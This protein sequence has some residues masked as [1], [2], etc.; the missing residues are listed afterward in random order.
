MNKFVILCGMILCLS[1]CAVQAEQNVDRFVPSQGLKMNESSVGM[2]I[3]NFFRNNNTQNNSYNQK[4]NNY[5]NN[6]ENNYNYNKNNQNKPKTT[7]GW[8]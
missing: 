6:Y 8:T 2:K 7:S 5:N 1:V 3:E 4:N